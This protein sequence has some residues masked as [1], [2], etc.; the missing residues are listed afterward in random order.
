MKKLIVII[1]SLLIFSNINATP[2]KVN[3]DNIASIDL[4]I[5][6]NKLDSAKAILP[7]IDKTINK[8]YI[9]FLKKV[10]SS[11][12]EM[13]Y[14]DIY[15]FTEHIISDGIHNTELQVFLKNNLHEPLNKPTINID[16]VKAKWLQISFLTEAVL[17]AEAQI[18]YEI[19]EKYLN[20][21]N[22]DDI[23]FLRAQFYKN[24][25]LIVLEVIKRELDTGTELCLKN[26]AIASELNDTTLMIISNYYSV[27]MLMIEGDLDGYIKLMEKN[28]YLDKQLKERT[29]Y[30]LGNLCKLTD[31]Y[32][33]KGEN[34]DKVYELLNEIYTRSREVSFS[35]YIQFIGNLPKTNPKVISIYKRFGVDN[36]LDLC[37]TI[38]VQAKTKLVPNEYYQLL[39]LSSSTLI[40][41]KYYV[42]AFNIKNES[43]ELIQKI[44]SVDLSEALSKNEIRIVEE[45]KNYEIALVKEKS[46]L[47]IYILILLIIMV[48]GTI[49]SIIKQYKNNLKLKELSHFKNDM[50]GMIVH[51]LK[52]PLNT[53]VNINPKNATEREF[54][55]VKSIGK[56]ML[57]LVLNILELSKYENASIDLIKKHVNL[58]SI[59]NLALDD[60]KYLA[61]QK[62]IQINTNIDSK[63][64][65]LV[66]TDIIMRVFNN[67]LANAIKY[68][69]H[70]KP[71]EI[72]TEILENNNIKIT[73]TDLGEGIASENIH[74]V[75][76]KY[77]QVNAKNSGSVMSTGIGLAFCKMAV[78][79]HN[80]KIGVS[81]LLGKGSSFWITLTF[82]ERGII[83]SQHIPE[84]Q[85]TISK[86]TLSEKEKEIL[87]LY[88]IEL[89]ELNIFA[90]TDVENV[91]SSIKQHNISNLT[92][93]AEQIENCVETYNK[94][95]YNELVNK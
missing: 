27:D 9:L 22:N 4:L 52:N 88:I 29:S 30:Y 54:T 73:I 34:E 43:I 86:I 25:Y 59:I 28:I 65:V 50:L 55:R 53:I 16:F 46:T 77:R 57:N 47:Y 82:S 93:W 18:E 2:K 79:S 91:I 8:K 95:K 14:S 80:G 23:N 36:L 68:S 33:Y 49:V 64:Y 78:E 20:Q 21:F 11:K 24:T 7:Y 39:R 76:D 32:L 35:Y 85:N 1:I 63:I 60:V 3:I 69:E 83:K 37:D 51:D 44:Y 81:S 40:K 42:E 67:L 89:K 92:S 45:K 10:L 26:E 5:L 41:K 6:S 70:N 19:L 31:A 66:N 87:N 61:L 48:L 75:F 74:L 72:N 71:I 58:Q 38:S 94:A 62:N 84:A 56:Q 12:S 90:V 13:S 15:I 17:M